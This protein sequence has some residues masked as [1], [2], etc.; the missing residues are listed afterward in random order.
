[1]TKKLEKARDIHTCGGCG[2]KN[3]LIECGGIYNCTN[4]FCL[5]SGA[6]NLRIQREYQDEN[7]H[8]TEDQVRKMLSDLD[9]EMDYMNSRRG[10]LAR[11]RE[12][13]RK[14]LVE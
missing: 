12:R 14:R 10:I 1:V 7:G 2:T 6:W 3:D 4:P 11:C 8:Q 9:A 5:A 13:L